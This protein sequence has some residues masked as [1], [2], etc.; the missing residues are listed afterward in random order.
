MKYGSQAGE[1]VVTPSLPLLFLPGAAH[2]LPDG[3]METVVTAEL[4]LGYWAILVTYANGQTWLT[5]NDLADEDI[6]AAL[7]TE[8]L[9]EQGAMVVLTE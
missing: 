1:V 4:P 9:P 3:T 2:L 7:G 6:A 5:P 8:A